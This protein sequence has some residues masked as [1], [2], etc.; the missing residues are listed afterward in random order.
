MEDDKQ[1]LELQTSSED[2]FFAQ[3]NQPHDIDSMI[4]SIKDYFEN[5]ETYTI[6]ELALVKHLTK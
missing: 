1:E 4:N 2:L 6:T 5:N 3:L